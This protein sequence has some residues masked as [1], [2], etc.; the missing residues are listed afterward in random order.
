MAHQV[1]QLIAHLVVFLQKLHAGAPRP[2]A[3]TH[4]DLVMGLV[5]INQLP[6]QALGCYFYFYNACE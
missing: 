5:L 6:D 3:Q 4:H 1:K 2:K